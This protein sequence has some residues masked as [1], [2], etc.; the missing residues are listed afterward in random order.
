[1]IAT[2]NVSGYHVHIYYRDAAERER[3]AVLRTMI[4]STFDARVGRW[5]DTPVGPHSAPMF[6]VAFAPEMLASIVPWLM[7]NRAGL[8]ILLHPETGRPRD[9]H[10]HHAVWFGE[11]LPIDGSVLPEVDR[12]HH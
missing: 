2:P 1:M 5:H 12:E 11:V 4:E 3:A 7:V 8:A 10:V 9:D 6:Q